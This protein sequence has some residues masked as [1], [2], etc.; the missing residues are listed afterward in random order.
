MM[1]TAISALFAA[2]TLLNGLIG[3]MDGDGSLLSSTSF[4]TLSGD[5]A[6]LSEVPTE[7]E[8]MD[9]GFVRADGW[10]PPVD[11]MAARQLS[12]SNAFLLIFIVLN[13]I[14][15]VGKVGLCHLPSM[16]LFL[17]FQICV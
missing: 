1:R 16:H 4:S 5:D 10:N 3:G 17:F 8:L 13:S 15:G 14:G 9:L 7:E 12:Q 6:T 11:G 2:M